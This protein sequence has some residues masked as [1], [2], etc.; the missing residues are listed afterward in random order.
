MF[1]FFSARAYQKRK[2][3]LEKARAVSALESSEREEANMDTEEA[4]G[5]TTDSDSDRYL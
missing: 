3:D 1:N 5:A 2:S 4:D